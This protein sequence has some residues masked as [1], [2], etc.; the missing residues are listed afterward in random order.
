MRANPADPLLVRLAKHAA[1]GELIMRQAARRE[2]ARRPFISLMRSLLLRALP[3]Q[4]L[5]VADIPRLLEL[6]MPRFDGSLK[7]G[8]R[9]P[10]TLLLPVSI[11]IPVLAGVS[12]VARRPADLAEAPSIKAPYWSLTACFRELEAY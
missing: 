8:F 12:R 10:G 3:Q 9:R 4:G 1:E 11:R 6:V 7:P 5:S 2:R